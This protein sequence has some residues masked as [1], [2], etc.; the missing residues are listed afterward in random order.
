MAQIKK[1]TIMKKKNSLLL[2]A[3]TKEFRGMAQRQVTFKRE[4][5]PDTLL[6]F[7]FPSH[8]HLTISDP[9]HSQLYFQPLPFPS[10]LSPT[11]PISIILF[12][13]TPIPTLLSPTN[14]I[15]T[16]LS[17]TSHSLL[18]IPDHSHLPPRYPQAT[19]VPVVPPFQV[20]RAPDPSLFHLHHAKECSEGQ[21]VAYVACLK[22][23]ANT[24][25]S[26]V[27]LGLA[28]LKAHHGTDIEGVLSK[29]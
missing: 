8:S 12:P 20:I 1:E 9:S 15:P 11:T 13:T 10:L 6:L 21:G 26:K 3:S 27:Q 28:L 16:L 14:P 18:A 2:A 4:R 24:E 17:L 19:S 5:C 22:S 29:R 23:R 25:G 7:L